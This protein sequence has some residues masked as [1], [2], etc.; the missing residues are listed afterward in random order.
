[1]M[2][3]RSIIAE[4][5]IL[6]DEFP[7]VCILGPRQI[8]KTTLAHDVPQ[9]LGM[10]SVY[11]DLEDVE[12]VRKLDEPKF[13]FE[14]NKDKLIILDEVQRVPEVFAVL[15]GVIDR[16]RREGRDNASFLILGS[17]SF[18]LLKQSS[19][20]LAGRIAY[21]YLG[22]INYQE[23]YPDSQYSLTDIWLRGGFPKSLTAA[24]DAVSFRWRQNFITTYLERELPALDV[25]IPASMMR[26]LWSLLA[27]NQACILNYA[28][29]ASVMDVSQ[30][31]IKKYIDILEDLM[32]VRRLLPWVE[33]RGKRLIKSPKIYVRDTGLLHTLLKIKD[34]NTLLGFVGV[35]DSWESFVVESVLSVLP[36]DV[37]PYYYRTSAGAEIDLLL[38]YGNK[39]I[40]IEIKK[41][42]APKVSKG[43]YIATEDLQADER[44]IVYMG[45]EDYALSDQLK[46][47]S[48]RSIIAKVSRFEQYN[49]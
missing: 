31:T 47:L 42:L 49:K 15:R 43:F 45:D 1:M 35:G 24:S 28:R 21:A 30:P 6:L 11:L 33:N 9:S 25:Y 32:L 22:G 20:S 46:V 34:I 5:R 27:E 44:Y 39:K 8:G 19:E 41:S 16:R 23:I 2:I 36:Q 29:F 7:A 14:I 18:D 37:I 40:A 4:M 26:K 48:V 17:A 13:F 12:D 38:D 3:N 10:D